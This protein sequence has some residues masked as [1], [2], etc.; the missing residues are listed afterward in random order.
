MTDE[1]LQ[2]IGVGLIAGI[3]AVLV[4]R[5]I[6]VGRG[7]SPASV[8]YREALQDAVFLCLGAALIFPGG[9]TGRVVLMS[10]GAVGLSGILLKRIFGRRVS[11]GKN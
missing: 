8:L 10:A 11:N 3:L 5:L 6:V 1:R 2:W 4:R 7:R 9:T